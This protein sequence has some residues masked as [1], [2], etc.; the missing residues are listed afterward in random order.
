MKRVW[1]PL[2]VGYKRLYSV[3]LEYYDKQTSTYLHQGTKYPKLVMA[4]SPKE[5]AE[6]LHRIYNT[7]PDSQFRVECKGHAIDVLIPESWWRD[8]IPADSSC[9][10]DSK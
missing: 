6:L 8:G 2:D 7:N 9:I 10:V 4:D 1:K 5:A 3:T